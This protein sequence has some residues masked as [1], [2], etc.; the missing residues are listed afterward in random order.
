MKI[1]DLRKAYHA[2]ICNEIIRMTEGSK[3]LEYPNF[4]D[5]S[6][7]SSREIALG[8][9]NSLGYVV[10]RAPIKEQTVG[11]LFE[12]APRDFLAQAFLDIVAFLV[13]AHLDILVSLEIVRAVT[14]VFLAIAD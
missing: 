9:T 11:D 7:K 1:A 14:Q 10:N 2:R 6:N 3:G 5:G 12:S 4:A 13:L 8:I